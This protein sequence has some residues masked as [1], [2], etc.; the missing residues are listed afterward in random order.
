MKKVDTEQGIAI[1]L[2]LLVTA[3]LSVIVLEFAQATRIELEIAKN[4]RDNLESY[5]IARSGVEFAKYALKGDDVEVDDLNEDWAKDY[6]KILSSVMFKNGTL[7]LTIVDESSKIN[8]N[9]VVLH[10][11]T[12]QEK[13]YDQSVSNLKVL[14]IRNN[15]EDFVNALVDWIDKNDTPTFFEGETKGG[16]EENDYQSMTPPYHCKNALLDTIKELFLIKDFT[17]ETYRGTDE[18]DDSFL[19]RNGLKDFITVYGNHL[20]NINTAPKEVIMALDMNID[21]TMADNIIKGRKENPYTE[22]QNLKEIVKEQKL[23]DRLSKKVS[24]KSAGYFSIQATGSANNINTKIN[25]V[26]YRA[27]KDQVY[28]VYWQII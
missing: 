17:D 10:Q 19:K 5:A 26:L 21:E 9:T 8:V 25:A 20:I 14:C 6:S 3:I 23:F 15:Q 27:S 28:M 22:I 18:K 7:K 24:F 11:G 2:T 4:Y 12:S 1:I 13:V 16:A